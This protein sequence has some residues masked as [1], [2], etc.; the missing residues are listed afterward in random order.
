MRLIIGRN[1]KILHINTSILL[2]TCLH[3]NITYTIMQILFN[4]HN[5]RLSKQATCITYGYANSPIES[6][7][8]AVFYNI[9]ASLKSKHKNDTTLNYRKLYI[10][11]MTFFLLHIYTYIGINKDSEENNPIWIVSTWTSEIQD[12]KL[13]KK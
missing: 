10:Y 7:S 8:T 4:I 2:C 9:N 5:F 12:P 3:N 13:Q 1:S 6:N 11:K